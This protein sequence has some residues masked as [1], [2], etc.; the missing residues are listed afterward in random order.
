VEEMEKSRREPGSFYHVSD[1]EGGK[2]V[3]RQGDRSYLCTYIHNYHMEFPIKFT[4][5]LVKNE[6]ILPENI[7]FS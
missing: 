5:R 7:Q 3:E 2:V 6:H 4:T 1:V